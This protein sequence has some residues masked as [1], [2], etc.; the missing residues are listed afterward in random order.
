HPPRNPEL[1]FARRRA[2]R[3]GP[4]HVHPAPTP[5]TLT[6]LLDLSLLASS[7]L[8]RGVRRYVHLLA[9]ELVKR[10]RDLDLEVVALIDAP[11]FRPP[12]LTTDLLAAIAD[13]EARPAL[14]VKL[15]F[16][17]SGARTLTKAARSFGAN[18][19]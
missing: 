4:P 17:G 5:M 9:G 6:V 15:P 13:W 10:K 8:P 1:R 16:G 3:E 11:F 2:G 18:V 14:G 19:V 12:R 7:T